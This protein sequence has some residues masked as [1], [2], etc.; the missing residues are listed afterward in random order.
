MKKY[1]NNRPVKVLAE[2]ESGFSLVTLNLDYKPSLTGSNWC[3]ACMVGGTSTHTCE[4]YDEVIDHLMDDCLDEEIMFV[5]TKMLLDN[6]VEFK[7]NEEL[8]KNIEEKKSELSELKQSYKDLY[9]KVEAKKRELADLDAALILQEENFETSISEL[10]ERKAKLESKNRELE[11]KMDSMF[12]NIPEKEL[13]HMAK[14]VVE[15]GMLEQGGVD[16]WQWYG[17]CFPDD[18]DQEQEAIDYLKTFQV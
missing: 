18:Y 10:K 9:L 12:V 3:T 16:N 15:L 1:Y 4:E 11:I 14:C 13:K 17:E 7:A 5:P 2:L 6:Y 8:K